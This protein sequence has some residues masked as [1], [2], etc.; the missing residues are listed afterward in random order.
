[1]CGNCLLQET[2]FI[3]PMLCPKG[4]RNGPCGSGAIDA[5]CVEPSRPC[6]WHLI[7]EQADAMGRLG[8][9]LEVQAP[10]DWDRV[11]RETWATVVTEARKRGLLSPVKALRD[12][13]WEE[14]VA[15]MFRDIRQPDWWQGDD[16]YHPPASRQPVSGLQAALQRGEFVV[17]A[18]TAPPVGANALEIQEKAQRLGGL[19]HAANVTQNPMASPRMSSLACGLLLAQYG[20]EPIVQLTARDYN[21]LALQS[22]ALGASALGIR[23]VLCLAGDPPTT[24]RGPAGELPYDLDTTQMLWILRRLRDEGRFLDKRQVSEPPQLFLGA[25]GSPN[26]PDPRLEAIRLEKKINAGAQYV[27]SQLCY[28]VDSLQRWLEALDR[29]HLLARVHV[30]VGIGPLHSAKVARYMQAHIPDV[31]VPARIIERMER[32]PDPQE[33]GLEIALELIHEI[34]TVPEVDGLHIMSVGWEKILP[35]LLREAGL[36]PKTDQPESDLE[37]EP[38][39]VPTPGRRG[40][41]EPR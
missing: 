16:R 15:Q 29:R 5:C 1:M 36:T 41:G 38:D 21:R 32:S 11:G 20:V 14:R 12:P 26:D 30:L 4:L 13:N 3:C 40:L 35:R 2:A 37:D 27:Q 33:T 7:Y 31:F 25:A 10:L 18:E 17:T 24:S 19:I 28:D 39:F 8:R 6:V 9:L 23:N 22:E 34:R